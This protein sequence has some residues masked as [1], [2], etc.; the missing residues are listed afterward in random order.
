MA[1]EQQQSGGGGPIRN[2][3]DA[4]RMLEEAAEYLARTEPHSPTPYLVR[5]AITWG[6]LK[7]EDLMNELIQ[8]R[9]EVE[10]IYHLLQIKK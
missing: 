7:F 8:N 6:Q 9:T 3:A 2:R 1:V 10:S 4:Y 5:R